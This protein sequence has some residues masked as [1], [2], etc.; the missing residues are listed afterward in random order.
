MSNIDVNGKT[1]PFAGKAQDYMAGKAFDSTPTPTDVK[2]AELE[3][4]L[5]NDSASK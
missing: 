5:L 1:N 2:I 4:S 3:R